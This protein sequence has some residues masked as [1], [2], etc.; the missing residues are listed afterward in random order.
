MLG[1]KTM[2]GLMF[3]FFLLSILGFIMEGGWIG[4]REDTMFKELT[5]Y[6]SFSNSWYTFILVL[7]G[8]FVNG[9]PKLLS[10]DYSFLSGTT[11]GMYVR[12][13][14]SCTITIGIVWSFLQLTL[15]AII[16]AASRIAGGIGGALRGLF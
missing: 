4:T 7:P 9:L 3:T 6:S 2:M 11:W 12:L 5:G 14:L 10:W 16:S 15:P 1:A 8:F 13:F